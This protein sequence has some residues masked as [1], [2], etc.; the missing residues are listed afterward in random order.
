MG[1]DPSSS[2]RPNVDQSPNDNGA[3]S[4]SNEPSFTMEHLR[5]MP[6]AEMSAIA[7]A[8]SEIEDVAGAIEALQERLERANHQMSQVAAV[9]TTEVEIGRLFLEAQRF[10]DAALLKLEGQIQTILSEAQAKADQ[11]VREAA[12][13]AETIRHNV[14]GLPGISTATARELQSAIAGFSAVNS[15]LIKELSSLNGALTSSNEPAP[16]SLGPS[17]SRWDV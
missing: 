17:E 8:T 15:E 7:S 5:A 14:Q 1:S 6:T 16:D 11:I 10:T 9:R 2:A 13:E 4:S 12:E 3:F